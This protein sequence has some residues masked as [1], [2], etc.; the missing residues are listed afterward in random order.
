MV[1]AMQMKMKNGKRLVLAWLTAVSLLLPAGCSEHRSG[2]DLLPSKGLPC[3][4]IVVCDE[5]LRR[6]GVNDSILAITEGP[7]PGLGADEMVFRSTQLTTPQYISAYGL[8]HSQVFF[9]LD[10]N[11]KEGQVRVAYDAK[12]RPQIIVTAEAPDVEAMSD[13]LGRRGKDIRRLLYDFQVRRLARIARGNPSDRVDRDL[14]AVA[15]YSVSV[16]AELVATKRGKNFLWAGTNRVQEDMN[17]LFYT[18][19]WD[20]AETDIVGRFVEQRDSVLRKN[21]PGAR[22]TQWMTTSRGKDDEPVVWARSVKRNGRGLVEVRGLWE[23]HDGFMGGPFVALAGV[24]SAERRVVV[25]EGFVYNPQGQKRDL[26]RRMEGALQTLK[27][28]K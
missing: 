12:A 22:P 1:H 16:P 25:A 17:F 14:R 28:V 20:P 24:D 26:M 21:I 23:L 18:Y 4:L 10:K 19:P 3:E 9:R 5:T 11:L 2:G 6:C 13:L 7:T 27:K 15:G 8:M